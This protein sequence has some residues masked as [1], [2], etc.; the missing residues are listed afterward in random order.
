MPKQQKIT[1]SASRDIPF[2]KLMLTQTLRDLERDGLVTRISCPEVPPRVEDR[3]TDLGLSLSD[4][5]RA[6]EQGVVIHCPAIL[7]QRRKV[8]LDA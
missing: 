6:M 4:L 5:A 7:E 2:D 1:L 3:L 8:G